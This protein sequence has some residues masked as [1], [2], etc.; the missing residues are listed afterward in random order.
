MPIVLLATVITWLLTPTI[1]VVWL[2]RPKTGCQQINETPSHPPMSDVELLDSGAMGEPDFPL[3][4]LE[5]QDQCNITLH[6]QEALDAY[7]I[8]I[9][10]GYSFGQEL[11]QLQIARRLYRLYH[12]VLDQ[13]EA[14]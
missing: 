8:E 7:H 14:R 11:A 4:W 5:L 9:A 1:T 2:A 13:L 3:R 10:H 12:E 6:R